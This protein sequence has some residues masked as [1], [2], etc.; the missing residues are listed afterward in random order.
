MIPVIKVNAPLI[1]VGLDQAGW[2]DSPPA[3]HKNLAGWFKD[4]VT[5]G[6]EGT[7]VIVGHV[8]NRTGPAVF[9][10]LGALRKGHRVEVARQDGRTAVF[11]IYGIEVFEKRDFPADRVYSDT[12]RPELR[13][14]TCGGGF[15]KAAGYTGNVVVFAKLIEGP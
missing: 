5:P 7:S 2:I 1:P 10:N 11:S 8:D 13:V 12:G 15:S 3:Q 6:E 9:Y 4:A 14:I